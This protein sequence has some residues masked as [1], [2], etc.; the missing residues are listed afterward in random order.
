MCI[1]RNYRVWKGRLPASPSS[2]TWFAS[3]SS[4]TDC[5][6]AFSSCASLGDVDIVDGARDGGGGGGETGD[7]G[8]GWSWFEKEE[9]K[10]GKDER[11]GF[12]EQFAAEFRTTCNVLFP[13][14]L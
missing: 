1:G 13:G 2:A 6:S 12:N 5:L 3:A 9:R 14:D 4:S 7:G 10:W 8:V 11:A